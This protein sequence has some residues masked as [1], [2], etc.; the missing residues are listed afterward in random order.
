MYHSPGQPSDDFNSFSTNLE[1]RVVKGALSSLRQ[2][3]AT[4]SNSSIP[5][6]LFR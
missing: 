6:N 1:K 4:E 5:T 3:V 2:F